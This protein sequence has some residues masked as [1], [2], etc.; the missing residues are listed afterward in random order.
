[1]LLSLAADLKYFLPHA[2]KER[3]WKPAYEELEMDFAEAFTDSDSKLRRC[4]IYTAFS[5][6]VLRLFCGCLKELGIHKLIAALSI[7]KLFT[8]FIN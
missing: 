3:L 2:A 8:R 1:L 6:R 7:F 4:R 5:L